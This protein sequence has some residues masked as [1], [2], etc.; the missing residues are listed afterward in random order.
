MERRAFLTLSGQTAMLALA[1]GVAK[2]SAVRPPDE[3]LTQAGVEQRVSTVI[4]AYDAQG[5]HRTGSEVDRQSGGWLAGE[6]RRL[7][8][9]PVLEPFRFNR[10]DLRSC[11]LRIADRRIDGVPLFDAGFTASK[12]GDGRAWSAWQ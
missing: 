1:A 4:E 11:Y 8:V 3:P 5:N 12:R 2:S 9:Q 6:V 7:G 10:V